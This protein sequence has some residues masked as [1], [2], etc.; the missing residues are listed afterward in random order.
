MS[1]IWQ[2]RSLLDYS[3]LLICISGEILETSKK[4][5]AVKNIISLVIN[6]SQRLIR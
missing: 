3:G 1:D 4:S 5:F 2:T 6:L